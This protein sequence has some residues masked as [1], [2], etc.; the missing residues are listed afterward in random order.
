M[1][2]GYKFIT[3]YSVTRHYGGPEEGGW[4]YNWYTPLK[5]VEVPKKHQRMNN[6]ATKAVTA[7]VEALKKEFDHINEGDIYSANGGVLLDV[8]A[9][10]VKHEFASTEQPHYC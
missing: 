1:G 6:R 5:T 4:W 2:K 9:E 8:A 7:K 10:Y 3:A